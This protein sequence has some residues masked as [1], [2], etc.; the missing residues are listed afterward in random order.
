M[1]SRER[2]FRALYETHGPAVHAYLARRVEAEHV[3]DL[4]S[5][6][7]MIAWR[8]IPPNVDEPLAWLYAV[9]RHEVLAHRRKVTR[10]RRLVERL[11]A[12]TPREEGAVALEEP[13]LEPE[14]AAAFSGLTALEQEALLLLAW[15]QLSYEQAGRVVGCSAEAFAVRVSRARRK[16]KAA[17]E[18]A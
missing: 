3:E 5:N 9:A 18:V 12:H 13:G 16:V 1:R 8:K 11:M 15:E 10:G 4:A 17:L 14:L 7:F 2:D 6:I